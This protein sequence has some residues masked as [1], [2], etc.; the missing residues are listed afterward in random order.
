M[1]LKKI[2]KLILMQFKI[3]KMS[4]YFRMGIPPELFFKHYFYW[5]KKKNSEY[6]ADVSFKIQSLKNS[7]GKPLPYKN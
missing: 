5:N 3:K 7:F 1:W 4:R 6:D 2:Q